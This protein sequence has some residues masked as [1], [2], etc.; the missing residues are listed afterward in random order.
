[1]TIATSIAGASCHWCWQKIDRL[2]SQGVGYI[3]F[4]DEIFLPQKPLLEAL[5]QRQI[6]FGVQTR[7]DLWKPDLLALLGSAGCVSIEAGIESLTAEGRAAL[8]KRCRLRDRG[9]G[10]TA[11]HRAPSRAVRAG[12]P[13]RHGAG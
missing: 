7:I 1:M 6:K 5:V 10:A 9:S 4:I 12:Q 11:V 13:D 8:A 3:Y 2:I